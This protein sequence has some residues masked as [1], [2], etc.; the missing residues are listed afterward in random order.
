MFPSSSTRS[1]G[2]DNPTVC[3]W[4]PHCQ[5]RERACHWQSI[6]RKFHNICLLSHNGARCSAGS[7]AEDEAEAKLGERCWRSCQ[8]RNTGLQEEGV[9]GGER[10]SGGI[11]GAEVEIRVSAR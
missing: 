5:T 1:S 11:K 7:G 4:P 6:Q 3:Q 8:G 9:G 2:E 10:R